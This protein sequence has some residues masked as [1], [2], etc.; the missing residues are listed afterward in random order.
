MFDPFGLI[1]LGGIALSALVVLLGLRIG[2]GGP[3]D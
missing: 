3:Q 1:L 2:S